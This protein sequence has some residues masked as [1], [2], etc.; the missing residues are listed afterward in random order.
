MVR[1][2]DN[3]ESVRLQYRSLQKLGGELFVETSSS[4]EKDLRHSL[5]VH[6]HNSSRPLV[7]ADPHVSPDSEGGT[8]SPPGNFSTSPVAYL[9]ESPER[10]PF[11]SLHRETRAASSAPPVPSKGLRTEFHKKISRGS[12][13]TVARPS[14]PVAPTSS[15]SGISSNSS[16]EVSADQACIQN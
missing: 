4:E 8:L 14:D 3:G 9:K 11:P 15:P 10:S 6:L 16:R 5:L 13:K 2:L 1:T 12:R 7:V